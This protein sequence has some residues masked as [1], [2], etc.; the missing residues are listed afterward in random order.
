[1]IY[2]Q[3]DSVFVHVPGA[4]T[5]EAVDVGRR[6]AQLVSAA[7]PTPMELKFESV[8]QPFMLLHV[9]RCGAA[10]PATSLLGLV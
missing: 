9:N 5:A 6:T 3:T 7:F 8:N 4:S 1:M 2:A 10:M